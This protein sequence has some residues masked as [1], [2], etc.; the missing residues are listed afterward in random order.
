MFLKSLISLKLTYL[1]E[2]CMMQLH[3][4]FLGSDFDT[5][6]SGDRMISQVTHVTKCNYL[7]AT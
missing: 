7:S 2:E 4:D 5:L 1:L 6:T 3:K